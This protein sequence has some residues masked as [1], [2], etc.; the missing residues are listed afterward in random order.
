MILFF[1]RYLKLSKLSNF[2]DY[3][4]LNYLNYQT[5]FQ[6]SSLLG[7]QG[8]LGVAL[9]GAPVLILLTRNQGRER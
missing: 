6:I 9:G 1:I 8:P 3:L 5:A 7:A 2:L 4:N